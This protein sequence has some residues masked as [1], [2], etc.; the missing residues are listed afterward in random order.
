MISGRPY[1]SFL[2][3]EKP[4]LPW[5]TICFA[6]SMNREELYKRINQ[7]VDSMMDQGLESEVRTLLPF[8]G[9]QALQTVGYRELFDYFDSKTGLSAAVS[10]IKQ[11]TRNFAKRQI[12]WFRNQGD[13][14]F[15]MAGEIR[16]TVARLKG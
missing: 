9:Y 11:H 1:S 5:N 13:Y 3:K 14:Q 12:T 15:M 8:R 7:R 2:G 6:I 16:D 10:A 4:E